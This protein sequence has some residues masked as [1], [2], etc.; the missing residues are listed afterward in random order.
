MEKLM[1]ILKKFN[2]HGIVRDFHFR[3]KISLRKKVG[4]GLRRCLDYTYIQ[5]TR[6]TYN[7][8]QVHQIIVGD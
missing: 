3:L 5:E 7:N 4:T 8:N 6:V 1:T 2:S